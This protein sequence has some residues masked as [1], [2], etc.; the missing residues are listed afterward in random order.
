LIGQSL[1]VMAVLCFSA[2]LAPAQDKDDGGSA[3]PDTPKDKKKP[4][5]PTPFVPAPKSDPKDAPKDGDKPATGDKKDAK[6]DEPAEKPKLPINPFDKVKDGDWSAYIYVSAKQGQPVTRETLTYRL[7]KIED[8]A[9]TLTE[10][11]N[12]GTATQSP[13]RE[14]PVSRKDPPTLGDFLHLHW[15]VDILDVKVTDDKHTVAGKE[16]TCKKLTFTSQSVD[17]TDRFEVWVSTDVKG[18]S[19][20]QMHVDG[21]GALN[22]KN[23]IHLVGFGCGDKVDW[24]KRADEVD[25]TKTDDDKKGK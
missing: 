14:N 6:E 2:P 17:Q 11:K 19:V 23:D 21:E 12:L 9:L 5:F 10:T 8:E 13:A 4:A 15:S 18:W 20:V 24:G 22:F 16:F 3:A 7:E 25:L 1:V